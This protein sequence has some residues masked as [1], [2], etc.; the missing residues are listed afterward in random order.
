MERLYSGYL[1]NSGMAH[2]F[3]LIADSLNMLFSYNIIITLPLKVRNTL[4]NV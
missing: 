4:A 2:N 1:Y 3:R